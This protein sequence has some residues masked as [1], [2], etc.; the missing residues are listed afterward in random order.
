MADSEVHVDSNQDSTA[1]EILN[2]HINH[3]IIFIM[4]YKLDKL[5]L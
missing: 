2:S 1:S 4:V 5:F 3:F